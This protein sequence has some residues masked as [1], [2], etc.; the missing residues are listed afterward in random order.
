MIAA[1]HTPNDTIM[2]LTFYLFQMSY[3]ASDAQVHSPDVREAI[4]RF[5]LSVQARL[6]VIIGCAKEK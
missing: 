1:C 5:F 2:C 4:V 3:A 6:E